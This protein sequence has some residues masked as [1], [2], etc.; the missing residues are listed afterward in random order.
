MKVLIDTNVALNI[1]LNQPN[2]Y[3]GSKKVFDLAET[4]VFDAFISTSAITD[5][6]YIASKSLGKK[7]ARENIKQ[8]LV[9]VF[10]PASVTDSH[11]YQALDLDWNDFED[12]VQYVV[13]ESFSADYI[14]TRNTTDYRFSTMRSK[15]RCEIPVVSPEEFL[16][17]ITFT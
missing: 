9:P 13:G 12:S 8:H 1:L 15:L 17:I 3:S 2:F 10:K 6:Y 5:I 11:I 7:V 14:V 16:K 4:G